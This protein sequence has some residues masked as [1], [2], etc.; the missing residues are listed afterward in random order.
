MTDPSK[1]PPLVLLVED[2]IF[3]RI[4]TKTILQGFGFIVEE[5]IDGKSG[6]AKLLGPPRKDYVDLGVEG[7]CMADHMDLIL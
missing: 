5:A 6:I 2:D 3:T 4:V 7:K 1:H